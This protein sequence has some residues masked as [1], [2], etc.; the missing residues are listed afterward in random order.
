MRKFKQTFYKPIELT[1][2]LT[3]E[4]EDQMIEDLK[5]EGIEKEDGCFEDYVSSYLND[6]LYEKFF[7]AA[8]EYEKKFNTRLIASD[9][10]EDDIEE[11]FTC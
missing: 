4:E 5:A 3:Q 10:D 7:Y 11:V 2:E 8:A 6:L 1:V 9:F